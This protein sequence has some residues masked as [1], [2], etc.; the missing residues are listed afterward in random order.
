MKR[1][2]RYPYC[3]FLCLLPHTQPQRSAITDDGTVQPALDT[4]AALLTTASFDGGIRAPPASDNRKRK[5]P[6]A[7]PQGRAN[8]TEAKVVGEVF[9]KRGVKFCDFFN[10]GDR[11]SHQSNECSF[12]HGCKQCKSLTHPQSNCPR[13]GGDGTIR[14]TS[15]DT[16]AP[17]KKWGRR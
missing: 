8:Q 3:T 7:S 9:T 16:K 5:A 14:K 13:L 6:N 10:D 4:P 17:K 11:C 1:I 15:K 2:T 12:H